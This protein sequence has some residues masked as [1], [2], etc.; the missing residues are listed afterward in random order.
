MGD[1]PD[2]TQAQPDSTAT[3]AGNPNPLAPQVSS[4]LSGAGGLD[5]IVTGFLQHLTDVAKTSP[6]AQ[7]V[8]AMKQGEADAAKP[9]QDN[10]QPAPGGFADKL[11]S[12]LGAVGSDASHASDTKGGWLTGIE[13]VTNARQQRIAQQQK[14]AVLLA[15]SQAEN[16]ALHRNFYQQDEQHRQQ[17]QEGNQKFFDQYRKS[18][19]IEDGI[20][21]EEL[22]N[23]MKS[24][25]T[26][27]QNYTA[28]ATAEV[29][30]LDKNGDQA[31]DK[32]GNPVMKPTYSV[33]K[34]ASKDGSDVNKTVDAD[35]SAAYNKLLGMKIPAGTKLT[36]A[37]DNSLSLQLAAVRDTTN[38]LDKANGKEL[39]PDVMASVRPLLSDPTVTTAI[40]AVPGKPYDG[41]QQHLKNADDHIA[42]AQ[43]EANAAKKANNQQALDAANA[44]IASFQEEKDKLN[45]VVNQAIS[46]KQIDDYKK[47]MGEADNSVAE[48]LNDPSKIQG[49]SESVIAA[50]DDLINSSKDPA[51]VAQAKRT[52]EMAVN[53]QK[54]EDE[55][56]VNLS[57]SE[58]NAKEKAARVD[59]NPNGLSGEAFIKTLPPGRA[60]LV[61]ALAEGRLPVNPTAF[62]RST[63][64]KSN[65]LADDV[66][67]AYPDFN[68]TLGAEWPKA[69]TNY[70]ISGNDHK[71]AGAYNVALL[72]MQNLWNHTT[73]KGM[74]PGTED[75]NARQV[76]INQFS[77]EVGNALSTGVLTQSEHDEI[78]NSLDSMKAVTPEM[79]RERIQETARLLAG[80][81]QTQQEQFEQVK[82]SAGI[83]VPQ[84]LLPNAKKSLDYVINGGQKQSPQTQPAPKQFEGK[85]GVEVGNKTHY[86]NTQAEAD[87][88]KKLAGIQ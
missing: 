60:N 49:H 28:R 71:K 50:A 53:V 69:W 13:N 40:A 58:Q 26:F 42:A 23:R 17:F 18:N 35:E 38:I 68:A 52:K 32:F 16:I 55:R 15:K 7:K 54:A 59:N 46:P 64:G 81:I 37:Q 76:D 10:P 39:S 62:E 31:M 72:H 27:A 63:A 73:V 9:V 33:M 8:S 4:L 65:P 34:L 43:A 19:D 21:Q 56:K 20:S 29:P 47:R 2:I 44:K 88:F 24:D 79:K 5:T 75:Y 66:F 48:Y 1:S 45:T 51:V 74:I 77:R 14:D 82:P 80:K 86:F 84:L 25:K 36:M 6:V 22:F 87:N 30:V 11:N 3:P 61:R 70:M 78:L 57:V 67:A 85:I 83:Q 12:A 41:I